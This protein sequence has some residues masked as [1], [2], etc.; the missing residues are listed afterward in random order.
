MSSLNRR[1]AREVVMIGLYA[2]ELSNDSVEHVLESIIHKRLTGDA[3][4]RDFSESLFLRTV[5]DRKELDAIIG[6]FVKNWDVKRIATIDR[7]VMRMALS[8]MMGWDDIPTKVSI[9]EAIEIVKKFSTEKSGQ[10]VNGILDSA[11]KKLVEEGK[12]SKSGPGLIEET[13]P[14]N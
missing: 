12:I 2:I 6:D 3:K 4:L 7:C 13:F 8:E 5:R 9:N 14:R 1:T 11:S 10:F